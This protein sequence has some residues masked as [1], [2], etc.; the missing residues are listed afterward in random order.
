MPQL[1][2][3]LVGTAVD[4]GVR[5]LLPVLAGVLVTV[6]ALDGVRET[7]ALLDRLAPTVSVDVAERLR[8]PALVARAVGDTSGAV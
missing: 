8:G 7:V 6:A 5:E 3:A 2:G 4:V 1:N